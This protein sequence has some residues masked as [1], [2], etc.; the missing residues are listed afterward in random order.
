MIVM[1]NSKAGFP[2]MVSIAR[3]T[4]TGIGI[5]NKTTTTKYPWFDVTNERWVMYNQRSTPMIVIIKTVVE[6]KYVALASP[7]ASIVIKANCLF[8][9]FVSLD[10]R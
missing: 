2:F 7:I 8:L 9:E 3:R 10:F 1:L 4:T 6:I 5:I